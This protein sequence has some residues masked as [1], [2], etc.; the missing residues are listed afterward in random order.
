MKRIGYYFYCIIVVKR[1]NIE[2]LKLSSM[3]TYFKK[4]F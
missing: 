1:A 2:E 3:P 4:I